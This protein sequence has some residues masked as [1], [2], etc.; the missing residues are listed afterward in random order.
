MPPLI[1]VF[2]LN[3]QTTAQQQNQ[4]GWWDWD[5][6]RHVIGVLQPAYTAFVTVQSTSATVAVALAP[7]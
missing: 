7:V 4:L 5:A 6:V 2:G 1:W 3:D